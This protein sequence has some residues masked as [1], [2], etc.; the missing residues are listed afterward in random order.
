MARNLIAVN[1]QGRV[2]LPV[3]VRRQLGIG[4]GSQLEVRVER[5]VV[6]LRPAAMIPAEDRRAYTRGALASLN[7]A[8]SDIKAGRVFA[9]S[10]RDLESGTYPKSRR[11][12][13]D[14]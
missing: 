12:S 11:R 3:D 14:S 4:E 1:K 9:V 7:R 5:D 10:A 8:I 6:E 13:G 2:T